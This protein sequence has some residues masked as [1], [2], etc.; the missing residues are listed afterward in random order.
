MVICALFWLKKSKK[1]RIYA[2]LLVFFTSGGA[3]FRGFFV[4]GRVIF[5]TTVDFVMP[6]G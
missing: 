1:W 3:V 2:G 4:V 6:L 5:V